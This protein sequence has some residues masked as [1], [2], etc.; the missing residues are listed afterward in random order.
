MDA[1]PRIRQKIDAVHSVTWRA[2]LASLNRWTWLLMA[3]GVGILY[4]ASLF[5]Q[6]GWLATVLTVI[7]WLCIFI[8]LAYFSTTDTGKAIADAI[9]RSHWR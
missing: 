6:T 1:D 2:R 7:G 4:L 5:F 8:A 9:R 3:F